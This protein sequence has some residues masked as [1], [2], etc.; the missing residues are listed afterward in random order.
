M[1]SLA[2]EKIKSIE[3]IE[4]DVRPCINVLYGESYRAVL[5]KIVEEW[6]K[7]DKGISF[8]DLYEKEGIM[9]SKNGLKIT[10]DVLSECGYL[11]FKDAKP[12]TNSPK[13]RK[14]YY[15][16]PLGIAMNTI[17]GLLYQEEQGIG[18][19]EVVYP[20]AWYYVEDTLFQRLPDIYDYM[21][22]VDK[23]KKLGIDLEKFVRGFLTT[24]YAMNMLFLKAV[25]TE[26]KIGHNIRPSYSSRDLL[27]MIKK[28]IIEDINYLE[29]MKPS[30]AKGSIHY[31]LLEYLQKEHD[32]LARAL[33]VHGQGESST[34]INSGVS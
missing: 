31:K 22:L 8:Y 1:E 28:N 18:E 19:S 11:E 21:V 2:R 6:G 14:D 17:L 25:E 10:L 32:K 26:K 30:V 9:K 5:K 16:T 4:K 7:N 33:G 27:E 15:P 12:L 13:R 20:L 23:E 24:L 29:K 3:E 34:Y